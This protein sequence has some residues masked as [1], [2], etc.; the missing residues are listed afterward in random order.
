MLVSC[1]RVG[2]AYPKLSP[3]LESSMKTFP[4]PVPRSLAFT[5][6]SIGFSAGLTVFGLSGTAYGQAVEKEFSVQRFDPAPGPRNYF[7]TRGARTDGKNAWSAGLFINYAWKPF[8][9]RSCI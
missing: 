2:S 7:T 1:E 4:F 9:V 3:A 6:C 5:A 8:V